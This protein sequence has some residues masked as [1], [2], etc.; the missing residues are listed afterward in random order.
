MTFGITWYDIL[1]VLTTSSA[2]TIRRAYDA[3]ARLLR[4]ELLAGAQSEVITS[5]SRA[6]GILDAALEVLG[7]H[8]RRERYDAAMGIRRS[9]GGLHQDESYPSNP[10]WRLSDFDVVV[11]IPGAEV[12]GALMALTDWLTPHTRQPK[13]IEVPDL[14]GLFYSV[15][16]GIVGKLGLRVAVIRLTEHPMAVDGLVVDQD[17]RPSAKMRRTSDLTVRIWHPPAL[18]TEARLAVTWLSCI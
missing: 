7:D 1:G 4:P 16:L 14:R 11:D 3:K 6:Q 8:V 2:E 17:P 15:C 10:G 18:A 12:L 5:A 13:R 9:G